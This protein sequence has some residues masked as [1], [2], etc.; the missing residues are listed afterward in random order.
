VAL[1]LVLAVALGVMFRVALRPRG[2]ALDETPP[3][4]KTDEVVRP[5]R[6]HEAYTTDE[7]QADR[8]YKYKILFL[9]DPAVSAIVTGPGGPL[10]ANDAGE[11]YLPGT[12][13]DPTEPSGRREVIRC[14]L[15]RPDNP[16]MA[17]P[18]SEHLNLK[19][20]C[21]GMSNG[22]IVLRKC[23]YVGSGGPDW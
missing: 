12:V 18:G 1:L 22:V 11:K 16:L 10:L 15:Y 8:A 3:F 17:G 21:V 4:P 19:G 9:D 23:Y 2:T 6:L 7:I 20:V 14:Y 13:A 5:D